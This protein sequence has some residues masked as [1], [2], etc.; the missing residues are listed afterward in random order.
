MDGATPKGGSSA[1]AST[2]TAC[3]K[4]RGDGP[5][6]KL[7]EAHL[8][9]TCLEEAQHKLLFTGIVFAFP[10]TKYLYRSHKTPAHVSTVLCAVSGGPSSCSM[11]Y[12]LHHFCGSA[13][14][15]PVRALNISA[16][17]VSTDVLGNEEEHLLAEHIQSLCG[18]WGFTFMHL[19]IYQLFEN[20]NTSSDMARNYLTQLLTGFNNTL[21]QELLD[22][23]R[24]KLILDIAESHKFEYVAFG[25]C[26]THIAAKVIAKT[27]TARASAIPYLGSWA[28]T[29]TPYHSLLLQPMKNMLHSEVKDFASEHNFILP[30]HLRDTTNKPVA[31]I[32]ILSLSTVFLH[33]LQP[34]FPSTVHT[35]LATASKLKPPQQ[36]TPCFLCHMPVEE[37]ETEV[38]TAAEAATTDSITTPTSSTT[39]TSTPT[40]TSQSQEPPPTDDN[41]ASSTTSTTPSNNTTPQSPA[42]PACSSTPIPIRHKALCQACTNL[43]RQFS[44]L[45]DNVVSFSTMIQRLS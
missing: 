34:E 21:K 11:L 6:K 40:S 5:V 23:L 38:P 41:K 7:R 35:I 15:D 19:H 22:L 43:G 33:N 10:K 39:L 1:A 24:T 27:C 14:E 18:K 45:T 26:G 17:F 8:C 9:K 37:A 42:Q 30:P 2:A 28:H 3:A 31:P 32:S 4:C 12:G 36:G 25:T 13:T 44:S 20:E 16:C 29:P